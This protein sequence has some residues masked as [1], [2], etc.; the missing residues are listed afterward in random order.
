MKESVEMMYQYDKDYVF[1]STK[2]QDRFN[3]SATPYAD[4]IKA[5]VAADYS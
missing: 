5:V 2:F 1:D 3:M 4:G